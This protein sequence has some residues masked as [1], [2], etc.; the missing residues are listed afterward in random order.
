MRLR[1]PKKDA[2]TT[3]KNTNNSNTKTVARSD[4]EWHITDRVY[5]PTEPGEYVLQWRWDNEQTPQIWTTCADIQVVEAEAE[6]A[7]AAGNTPSGGS[8]S[9]STCLLVATTMV[10]GSLFYV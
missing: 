10:L 3:K 2:A 8:S 5:A 6:A 1:L 9:S 7:A 4:G